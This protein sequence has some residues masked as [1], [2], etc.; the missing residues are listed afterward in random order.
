MN[1]RQ[2]PEN[3]DDDALWLGIICLVLWLLIGSS[4]QAQ[5]FRFEGQVGHCKY[6]ITGKGGWWNDA[7]PTD[8]DRTDQCFQLGISKIEKSYSWANVGWR[9]AYVNLGKLSADNT[10]AARDDQQFTQFDSSEC[11]LSNGRNCVFRGVMS[12]SAKGITL[13]AIF[14]RK[15]W[16]VTWGT[17]VGMFAYDS[18]F[19]A[20]FYEKGKLVGHYSTSGVN[21]TPYLGLTA[22]YGYL[23]A[24]F[25]GYG[26]VTSHESG[27]KGCNGLA[28]GLAWSG[29]L[30]IQIP[31]K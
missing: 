12:D 31:V 20:T 23:L 6:G 7:Y 4:A 17:E 8:I 28:Q 11:D 16:A 24:S 15:Q 2:L 29:L 25:R 13:G 3:Q 22:N 10:F 9:L 1:Y 18:S 5:E 19:N 14:E 30:G 27:C 21:F 26:S